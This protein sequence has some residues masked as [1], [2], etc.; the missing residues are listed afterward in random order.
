MRKNSLKYPVEFTTG[1]FDK[2]NGLLQD[3]LR[4]VAGVDNPKVMLVA[5]LNVVQ[6]IGGLGTEIGAYLNARGITLVA[7]PTVIAAGEKIKSDSLRSAMHM[8]SAALDAK[9]GCEDVM[10][11]LG[12]GSLMDVAGWAAA[13]VRGGVKTIRIPTT[14]SAMVDG[15]FADYAALDSAS[16][17]DAIRVPCVPAAV[18]VDTGFSKG[19]LDGVWRGGFAAMVRQAVTTDR[20]FFESLVAAAPEF[21]DR[22]A[23]VLDR[24]VREAF[25][26]RG[27]KGVDTFGEWAALRLEAMSGY[28]L[29]HGYSVALGTL[30]DAKYANLSGL[31]KD[32]EFA[33]IENV[34]A[35]SGAKEG[36]SHCRQLFQQTEALLA[37]LSAWR[38]SHPEGIVVPHGIGKSKTIE[39]PDLETVKTA[40]NMIK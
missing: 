9:I 7:P 23:A 37:G 8:V 29:P 39:F 40:L 36:S 20:S 38:L 12:G 13:Q 33:E 26:S 6:H 31:L 5:D 35:A 15:A 1:L 21:R 17:K 2:S 34:L 32:D 4:S 22:D 3:T 27:K 14:P 24:L 11:I 19:V 30:I 28:K 25:E 10:L 18:L 16:I